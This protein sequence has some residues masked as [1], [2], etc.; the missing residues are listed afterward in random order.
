MTAVDV[1][2][3]KASFWNRN[4]LLTDCTSSYEADAV[5][6]RFSKQQATAQTLVN[7]TALGRRLSSSL[8]PKT[9]TPSK[10]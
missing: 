8:S 3:W 9:F 10:G 7:S 4:M 2:M 6:G 5:T 1:S